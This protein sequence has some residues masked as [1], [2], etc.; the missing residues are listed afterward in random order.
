MTSQ[1][2]ITNATLKGFAV[3][4]ADTFAAGPNSGKDVSAN[5]RKGA[6]TGQP[7]QGFSA[8]QFA[9]QN[10][11]W[12]LSDNGFGSKR[13]SSDYLLRIYR[14]VPNF[15]GQHQGDGTIN[16]LEF[17][18]LADPD[19]RIPFPITH[20]NTIDRWLTG[21]D[22]DPESLVIAQDGTFWIGDE[23]GPYLLHFDPAG[24]LLQAPIAVPNFIR[25]RTLKGQ[26]PIVIAHRGA[27][28]ERPEHTL[29]AYQLAIDQGADFIEPDL[30]ATKDGVLIARHEPNITN[31]TDVANHPEFVDRRTQKTIDGVEQAGFFA[32]DFTL[33]EIKTLRAVMPQSFRSQAFNGQFDIPTLEE[34]IQLVQQEENRTGRKIGIYPET[35]HPTYHDSLGLS[36]EEKLIN[37]L[38][39]T[40]FTDPSRVFI[41]SF[42]VR[43]LKE[44]KASIMPRAGI[45]L[46]LIQLLGAKGS[47][48]DGTLQETQPYDFVMSGDRRTYADL[49]T[50]EGLKEIATYATGIGP[51]K[52][53]IFPAKVESDNTNRNLKDSDLTTL[54]PTTLVQDAHAAGLQVHPYTFRNEAHF[55]AADYEGTPEREYDQFLQLGVDGFFTDFPGTGAFVRNQ[56]I[57]PWVRSPQNPM[58]TETIAI[59]SSFAAVPNLGSSRGFE[60]MA[61]T[62]DRSRIYT[63]LEGTVAGDAPRTLR[64]YRFNPNHNQFEAL[65]GYYKLED[66]NHAIGDLAVVNEYEYLVIERDNNQGDKATFKKI[67]KIDLSQQ[68]VDNVVA[69]EEIVDLLNI[70]D[71]NNLSGSRSKR[72]RFPFQTIENILVIDANTILVANDNNYPFSIGR[73]P[74]ID[75][76]EIILLH[77]PNPL[78]LDPRVGR[79]SR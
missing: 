41:Q 2:K 27:S 13:N 77:L 33:A 60:G 62:P 43:N 55:L 11:F 6:F 69:K 25:L 22:F 58:I 16:I 28:G 49:R 45:E 78:R 64:V 1:P 59:Q 15:R 8:V 66:P 40:K 52:R 44:L 30:V 7:I 9:D 57:S 4:P 51:W 74:N 38:V 35:K 71:P 48:S 31:T 76:T 37:V 72:F 18:Q 67:F 50:P 54:S 12:F 63:L 79:G 39:N 47:H 10:T 29:A 17:L 3:L 42:E 21:A 65:Q 56:W 46:P 53:M 34:I 14:V 73:P 61:I 70:Q 68:D 26:A 32:S 23:F 36:L 19:K 75:N 24:K 5:D 20:E